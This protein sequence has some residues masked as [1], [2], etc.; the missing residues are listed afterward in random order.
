MSERTKQVVE[1]EWHAARGE[2]NVAA[3]N[4]RAVYAKSR[5]PKDPAAIAAKEAAEKAIARRNALRAEL[6]TFA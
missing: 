5:G 3:E 6:S 4:S 2:A 1:A